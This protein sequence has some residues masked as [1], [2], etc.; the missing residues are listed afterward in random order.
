MLILKALRIL[1]L[2]YTLLLLL[3]KAVQFSS[4]ILFALN[5]FN[6]IHMENAVSTYISNQLAERQKIM[7]NIHTIIVDNDKTTTPVVEV[8]MRSEMI[9]YKSSGLMK[10]ALAGMKKYISLHLLPIYG[11]SELYSKYKGLLPKA[12]FQKGCINFN[13]EDELP[14]EIVKQLITDCS[15][16]DLA[17]I[18]EDYQKEKAKRK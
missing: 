5:Q 6:N 18:K 14:M 17:K 10:Y 4:K 7:N 9:V 16:I 11:S 15:K 2:Y 3:G 12:N 8:M 13:S 1:G